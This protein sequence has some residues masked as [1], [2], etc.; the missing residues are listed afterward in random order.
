[1]DGDEY[2]DPAYDAL[3]AHMQCE[4]SLDAYLMGEEQDTTALAWNEKVVLPFGQ[5]LGSAAAQS[6]VAG[7]SDTDYQHKLGLM[8]PDQV[9]I[10]QALGRHIEAGFEAEPL[11]QF[12]TGVAGVNKS[13]VI[14]MLRET[15]FR[16]FPSTSPPNL[17]F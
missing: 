12:I 1:M 13:F 9:Q 6:D 11:R 8:S 7:M 4:Q 10:L 5:T 15:L 2:Q 16:A 14:D 17:S 3:N